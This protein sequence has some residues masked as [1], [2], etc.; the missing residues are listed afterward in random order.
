MDGH[1]TWDSDP[2]QR[3]PFF[4]LFTGIPQLAREDDF[5]QA[6]VPNDLVEMAKVSELFVFSQVHQSLPR[7]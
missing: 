4:Q 2:L 3:F 1:P 7:L 6:A 5:D